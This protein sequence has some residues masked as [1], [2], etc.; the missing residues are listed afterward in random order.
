MTDCPQC[1]RQIEISEVNY[2]TLFNC[3]LCSA[4]YFVGWDGQPELAPT[5]EEMA[6]EN[7]E[8]TPSVFEEAVV[9]TEM[10]FMP[11]EN[12]HQETIIDNSAYEAQNYE[13]LSEPIAE[14][15]F[16]TGESYQSTEAPEN[17]ETLDSSLTSQEEGFSGGDEVQNSEDQP[18]DFNQRL[19][20]APTPSS[21]A[22]TP[23]FQEVSDFANAEQETGG[24]T[25]S[26][27]I[28]G[29]DSGKIYGDLRD[30]LTDS[31]F[32][33]DTLALMKSIRE[34]SMTIRGLNPAKIYVVVSRVKYLSVKLSWRQDVL[35]TP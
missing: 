5:A 26:L 10:A 16:Q 31:R 25:Y 27:T 22:D 17:S 24:M 23:D 28:S 2:G 11:I 14:Q 1:H 29:I 34:G 30:A 9:E 4:V 12:S 6:A 15:A 19:D 33:W 35:A 18:Y 13:T 20:E 32:G 3:P 8:A 21:T 7:V